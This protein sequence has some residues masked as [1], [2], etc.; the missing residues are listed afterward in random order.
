MR[1][2]VVIKRKLSVYAIGI[3]VFS[4]APPVH[5]ATWNVIDS[6][7]AADWEATKN[8][9]SGRTFCAAE[10]TSANGSVFRFAF[11]LNGESR[12]IE[13]INENWDMFEGPSSFGIEFN[14]GFRLEL[15]GQSHGDAYSHDLVSKKSTF[16]F[17]GLMLENTEMTI[18]NAN[19]GAVAVFSLSGFPDALEYMMHCT[20]D[21]LI[22]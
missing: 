2:S 3:F 19:R 13:I 17:F 10:T 20:G 21:M 4:I 15:R 9:N 14:D 7:S 8:D 11:Y 22:P 5:S 12:F 1:C 6:Y 18:T 16:M